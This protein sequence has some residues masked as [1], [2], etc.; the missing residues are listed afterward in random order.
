VADPHQAAG[1]GAGARP[2][3]AERGQ[4]ILNG[5][6]GFY[7]NSY[8][9]LLERERTF[10]DEAAISYLKERNVD[11]I[12]VHGRFMAPDRF[13]DV[14]GRLAVRPDLSVLGEFREERGSDMLFRLHRSSSSAAGRARES[15]AR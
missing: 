7:P 8:I 11:V 9:E 5:Y 3:T 4:P 13:S 12:V 15:T 2:R 1:R 10:P 14:I 6:S